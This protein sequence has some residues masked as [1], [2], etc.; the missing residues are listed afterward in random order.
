M[1]FEPALA[2]PMYVFPVQ[3]CKVIY[4][5]SH[6]NYPATDILAPK[7]CKFVAPIS[8]V[9]D[10]VNRVDRFSWKTNLGAD[11]GGLYISIIGDDGVRYYGSHL[12]KV[13]DGMNPGV[14]VSAGDVIG[15]VGATGDSKGLAHMC[16]LEFLGQPH[17]NPMFGGCVEAS[18]IPGNI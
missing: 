5:H 4:A 15:L 6:H 11:R 10:E 12:S 8:G 9:V 2:T 3:G 17:R 14:R 18:Y 7:G 16:T 1:S 13:A